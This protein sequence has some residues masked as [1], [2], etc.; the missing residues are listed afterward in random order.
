MTTDTTLDS[1]LAEGRARLAA[2]EA[3]QAEADRLAAEAAERAAEDHWQALREAAGAIL[4]ECLWE[5]SNLL[6]RPDDWSGDRERGNPTAK[7]TLRVEVGEVPV[8]AEFRY[9]RDEWHLEK[10]LYDRATWVVPDYTTGHGDDG[11]AVCCADTHSWYGTDELAVALAVAE[12]RGAER[13]ALEEECARQR[14]VVAA[15]RAAR[16]A[17]AQA[18]PSPAERLLAALRDA[19]RDADDE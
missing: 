17:R 1:L 16:A 10:Q 5:H 2:L 6:R 11:P 18:E 13:Q 3:E 8:L 9:F 15:R 14:E 12:I 19:L 7:F 4:P